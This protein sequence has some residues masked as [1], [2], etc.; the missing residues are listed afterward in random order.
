MVVYEMKTTH[1]I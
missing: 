1:S